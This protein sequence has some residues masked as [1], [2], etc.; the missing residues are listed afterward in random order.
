MR[1]LIFAIIIA[2]TLSGCGPAVKHIVS[3]EYEQTRPTK[4]VVLPLI[5]ELEAAKE[6]DDI[7]YLFR[8]MTAEKLNLLNYQTVPLEDVE[9]AGKGSGDWFTGKAPHEVA[10][11]F[12]ADSVL[13]IRMKDWDKH[14]LPP[15][16]SLEIRASF[17]LRS[18][19]GSLLWQAEYSSSEADLN[20]DSAPMH[21][22][23]YK[24]YE[25]RVQ[26]FVDAIFTT[27][28]AGQAREQSRKTYFKWLP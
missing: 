24:A 2:V 10:A 17:E 23:L 28:P 25:P 19:N 8:R 18:A 5:W 1:R 6:A 14:S 12:G 13:F 26:R 15:Y 9:K 4:V 11:L 20:I 21:L 3:P 22:A 7:S 16:A 27:L